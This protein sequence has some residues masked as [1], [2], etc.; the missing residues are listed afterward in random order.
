METTNPQKPL[1]KTS[2]CVWVLASIIT[3][4]VIVGTWFIL[5]EVD[6]P[7]YLMYF[8]PIVAAV[9]LLVYY[10]VIEISNSASND[11]GIYT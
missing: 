3:I 9:A 11:N 7:K 2:A 8:V 5:R 10:A 1:T 6:E 4:T